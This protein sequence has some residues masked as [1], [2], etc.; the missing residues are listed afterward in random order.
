M[1]WHGTAALDPD[2]RLRDQLT[3]ERLTGAVD[4]LPD[5]QLLDFDADWWDGQAHS[6]CLVVSY[7]NAGVR[8]R[9]V[10]TGGD[11]VVL[12]ASRRRAGR[13]LAARRAPRR[14]EIGLPPAR[15][16]LDDIIVDAEHDAVRC[17][18][19]GC[20][21]MRPVGATDPCPVCGSS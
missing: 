12:P 1:A 2:E 13:E 4:G 16:P 15:L 7:G 10:E 20:V 8:R 6:P 9:V 3:I 19:Q 5:L 18:Y 14:P 17:G 11:T 21:A